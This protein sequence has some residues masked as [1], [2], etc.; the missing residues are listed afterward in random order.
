MIKKKQNL[1][2]LGG[3]VKVILFLFII[4]ALVGLNLSCKK[5]TTTTPTPSPSESATQTPQKNDLTNLDPTSALEEIKSNYNTA[6]LKATQ[7]QSGAVL[8]SASAKI[9]PTLDWQDVVEVYTFGSNSQPNFWWTISISVRSKNYIRAIIPKEDYLGSNL[10]TVT[11]EYWKINY[12]EAF[13][14]AE[15]NGGKEWREKQKS[16]NYQI[17]TTLAHGDPKNYLYWIVEYQNSDGSD[18]KTVQ[19]NAYN[20]EVVTKES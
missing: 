18:K 12:V 4:S 3:F 1:A 8:Y 5:E 16:T 13:Q 9:T 11:L 6:E 10:R 2:I 20:G 15:R 19:I 14:I 17:T 7:W